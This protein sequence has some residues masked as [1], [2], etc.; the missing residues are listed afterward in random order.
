MDE[1]TSSSLAA[2][3][4]LVESSKR[5]RCLRLTRIEHIVTKRGAY[6]RGMDAPHANPAAYTAA[7]LQQA[8]QDGVPLP[9]PGAWERRASSPVARAHT[10][11]T[12]TT[13]GAGR[14]VIF[15]R[16]RL[17]REG[18]GAPSARRRQSHPTFLAR[19][20]RSVLRGE[21]FAFET[22][23]ARSA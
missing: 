9:I 15:D 21:S 5:D 8:A 17:E 14:G 7:R 19:L 18:G 20:W 11:A 22:Q 3:S 6:A 2:A 4:R 12:S 10:G 1:C 13:P 23:S 16:D